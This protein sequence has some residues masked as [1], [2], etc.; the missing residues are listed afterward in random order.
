MGLLRLSDA[1]IIGG[2]GAD[3]LVLHPKAKSGPVLTLPTAFEP[4]WTFSEITKAEAIE[5]N[6]TSLAN[7]IHSHG[8]I[9]YSAVGTK[10]DW[11]LFVMRPDGTDRRKLTDTR[12]FNETGVRFSPDG[13][14]MLY[15]RQPVAEPVDNNTYGT[16]EL[17]LADANGANGV[18]YGAEWPWACWGPDSTSFASITPGGIKIVDAS[19]RKVLRGL[20]RKGFVEQL[21]W[22]PDGRGFTGTANG[23]G[24]F[25]TIGVLDAASGK[26]GAAS[27]I[28]RYNCTP[29]W[30]PDSRHVLYSR[31]IIP[32][33]GGRAELW[34]AASD[35]RELRMLYAEAGRHVY[36]G[37]SSPD[38]RYLLF[39]RSEEDLGRV[40]HAKTTMAIIRYA[41]APM[42]GDE[43]DALRKRFPDARRGSR[44]DL[45]PGWEPH[46]TLAKIFLKP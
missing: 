18:S 43:S 17:V 26:I 8:W 30:M 14:R 23:L 15:Y 9:A 20:P 46:W 2:D 34:T 27:E 35:G 12:E 44:L 41:D 10:G 40:A 13:K 11:D 38:G 19:T 36:G 37:A 7:E 24:Q 31:G 4:C 29:D 39:T 22:S 42:L 32:N 25:W 16:F 21:S 33:E 6:S 28:E 3:L 45:G 1:P 5:P